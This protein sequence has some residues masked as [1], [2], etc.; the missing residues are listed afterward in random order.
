[1]RL[2]VYTD[3]SLRVLMYLALNS[4]RLPTI[5]EIATTNRVSKNHLMKVVYDLGQAGYVETLRG[6]NGGLRLGREPEK[7]GLG[8]VVRHSEPDMN[9][10]PCFAASATVCAIQPGCKLR[11]VLHEASKA[12]L[13][14]LDG[15]SLA[16]L[17]ANKDQLT[18]LLAMGAPAPAEV[19]NPAPLPAGRAPR[20]AGPAANRRTGSST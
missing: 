14:V 18:G 10:V 12:F 5:A 3:Y 15:Y 4:E 8:D 6:R 1:M 2:T 16:D 7:I 13:Q 11:V 17:V 19:R 9:L 20:S